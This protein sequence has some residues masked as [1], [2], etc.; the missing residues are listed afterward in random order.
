MTDEELKEYREKHTVRDLG[1]CI[2]VDSYKSAIVCSLPFRLTMY[3]NKIFQ[4]GKT[5][6]TF[7]DT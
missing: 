6:I 1:W 4:S 2:I 3:N 7:V 5:L